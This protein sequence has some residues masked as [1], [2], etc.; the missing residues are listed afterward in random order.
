MLD[1]SITC[2]PV[3]DKE[4]TWQFELDYPELPDVNLSEKYQ[5]GANSNRNVAVQSSTNLRKKLEREGFLDEFRE[6]IMTAVNKGEFLQV[7]DE[8]KNAHDGLALSYQLINYV[9]K[10]TSSTTKLRVI[11]NSSIARAGGSLNDNI[12]IGVNCMNLALDVLAGWSV[13]GYAM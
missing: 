13:F 12:C 11:S 2:V 5:C 9:H 7:T 1:E 8:V 4:N 10:S 3:P 6:Q